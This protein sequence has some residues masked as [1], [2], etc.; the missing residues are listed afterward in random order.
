M[1]LAVPP[2][3]ACDTLDALADEPSFVERVVFTARTPAEPARF[4]EP[5]TGL[6]PDLR[7]C[8][9][10]NGITA[11]WEHQAR[12]VDALRDGR[13]VVVA[14]GTAS[15]KSLC[16][17]LPIVESVLEGTQDTALLVF[18]T[19]ALA[20]DQLRSLRTWLLP[21]LVASTY[22]GDTSPDERSWARANATVL[23]TNPEMLHVGI[24]PSHAKWATF[25]MR[26]RYVVIDELHVL[27]GVFG[28]HVA[29]VLRRL[30]RLCAQ[31]GSDPAFCFTSATIGNPAELAS[32]LC[33]LPVEA[34]AD[35]AAPRPERGFAVWQRPLLDH[36]SGARAS[37][38]LETAMLMSRFVEDGHQTLAFTRSR[39]SA[40][41][42]ATQARGMLHEVLP[43]A[44][45]PEI[46]AYRAGYLADERRE[47]EAR[48][49]SGELGGV[50]AT[51]ALELGIDVGALD[52][53]VC[54]GFPGTLASMRQQV[55]RAGRGTR[56]AA[57]VLVA[58]D[59]Q[60]DQWYVS[61]PSEL[62]ARPTEAA[63]VNP[64]NPFVARAQL[65][66]A[67]HERPL[68]HEDERWFG[69]CL[70]DAVRDLVVDD[71][72]R[73]RDGRV[74]WVGRR[75]P[76]AGVG[77]RSGSTLEY[78]LVLADG[79][80]VGTV[81][82]ARVF[83]VAHPGAIYLHQGRQYRVEQLDVD[84]HVAVLE[85]ADDLDEHT[86]P[87]EDT[88][89]AIVEEDGAVDLG[90]GRA[91]LGSVVVTHTL[92]AYQRRRSSTNEIIDT[93]PLDFPP[94]ELTTRACWYTVPLSSVLAAGI[95]PTQVI[96]AVH[97]AEHALIGLLPLFA[98]CDRWD[99]GGVSMALHPQTGDPTIFVY[100]GYAGGAG[101]AELAYARLAEHV[102]A[103]R[104]LV[105]S[106]PC[107]AGC[108]SCVQSPKCG[109]WNEHLDKD[110]A[111]RLLELF[112]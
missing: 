91:H 74:Y 31:Y 106:C 84:G 57:A 89:I 61:H 47:L 78:Q 60:L 103:A 109:N 1:R 50:V 93:V 14:T 8:L 72:V 107:D 19:K 112:G 58:G 98:I 82:S 9:I 5:A 77:L 67:A 51:N 79:R 87:R 100:D 43:A 102:T 56:R 12:A 55:G 11:L 90:A 46:A 62:L 52:A 35:D 24:L 95:D 23:L 64:A 41:L 104:E 44:Q 6:S 49:T 86:Q 30:R 25:L 42:V 99:V 92:V 68:T 108:P 26:L 94:R 13:S 65:A 71:V 37:A 29:H 76:A 111:R 20:Q 73:V 110:A 21:E 59:D 81:D 4:A 45:A 53:V 40:E 69:E 96:G 70:D 34:I 101:I 33:G 75:P 18:P 15:G 38:N 3:D 7:S 32:Q 66:C 16:Y 27:R 17:Q 48:L 88:D 83:Q 54:N 105:A 80:L 63:V 10:R 36:H 22:D 28:S 85:A 97:A 2:L 39:R